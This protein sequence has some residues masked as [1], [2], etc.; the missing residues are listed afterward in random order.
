MSINAFAI[1]QPLPPP[2][3]KNTFLLYILTVSVRDQMQRGF[4]SVFNV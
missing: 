2:S 3:V 4:F 1:L